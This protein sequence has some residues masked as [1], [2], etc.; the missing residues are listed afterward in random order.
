MSESAMP[1]P[2]PRSGSGPYRI[3]LLCMGNICRSPMAE[4]VV[5][6][7]L[8]EAESGAVVRLESAGVGGWHSG[9]GMDPR[10]LAALKQRGYDGTAHRARRLDPAEASG[11]DLIL[12]MDAGNLAAARAMLPAGEARERVLLF[13]A[14]D[15]SAPAGAEVPDPYYGG[16][17]NFDEV[18]DL[19][20]AAADGL[21][22]RLDE[23]R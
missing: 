1:L 21:V 16:E 13:R 9:E 8:A 14:F 22:E 18:L 7:R 11:Y 4:T 10:A 3:C 15:R 19:V 20:E 5:R 12:A 17:E 2:R 23:S 6:S